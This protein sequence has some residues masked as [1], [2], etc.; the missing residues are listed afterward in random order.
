MSKN[1]VS[2]GYQ[3]PDGTIVVTDVL[4]MNFPDMTSEQIADLSLKLH[5]WAATRHPRISDMKAMNT[6]LRDG[7]LVGQPTHRT[8]DNGRSPHCPERTPE[9]VAIGNDETVPP[10]PTRTMQSVGEFV[11]AG[12]CKP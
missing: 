5:C 1:V 2:L 3:A 6:D 11:G 8:S 12:S 9:A 10:A 7:P 4:C